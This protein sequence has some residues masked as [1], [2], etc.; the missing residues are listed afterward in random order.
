MAFDKKSWGQAWFCGGE[1]I[2]ELTSLIQ[3]KFV[4]F[5]NILLHN[6]GW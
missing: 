6:G 4:R 2:P 5:T 3:K 1:Y